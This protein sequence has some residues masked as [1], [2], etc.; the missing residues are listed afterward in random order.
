MRPEIPIVDTKIVKGHPV[1]WYN[2]TL[3]EIRWNNDQHAVMW[4]KESEKK[5]YL[6]QVKKDFEDF[7]D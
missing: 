7:I 5:K 4:M 2:P 6:E 3:K 1:G